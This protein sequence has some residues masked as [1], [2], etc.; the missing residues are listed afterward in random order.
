MK[1]SSSI[2]YVHT[3]QCLKT[4]KI[5][6]HSKKLI[7]ALIKPYADYMASSEIT[8][9]DASIASMIS[10]AKAKGQSSA[11][12]L[13]E[14]ENRDSSNPKSQLHIGTEE[15]KSIQRIV[16]EVFIGYEQVLKANNALDFDDLLVY[17]VKLF[18]THRASVAWC[19]HIL[20][21]EL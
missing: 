21:D 19:K 4:S 16:A 5:N 15:K 20:V 7:S 6:Y 3:I 9:S 1:G 13:R 8:L 2:L 12:F 11:T 18:S 10:K 14:I 17:G